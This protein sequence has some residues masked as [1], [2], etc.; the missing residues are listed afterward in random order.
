MSMAGART[1]PERADRL[2]FVLFA[3]VLCLAALPL[4]SNRLWAMG[5]LA[6][7]VL[8]LLVAALGVA[9]WRGRSAWR[10]LEPAWMPL[11][12]LLAYAGLL[13]GQ[14][15]AGA[16]VDPFHTRYYLIQTL[17]YSGGFAL[18]LL[19]A[20]SEARITRLAWVLVFA[21]VFQA[22]L[23]IVL[24][25][26]RAEY[27]LFF[28]EISHRA[29][30]SGSFVN[31][32][33]LAGYME[34]CLSL[35]IGLML[36][37]M[38]EGGARA[39]N[40]RHTA[41][42]V[43][44]FLMSEKIRLRLMLVVMVIALVLTRSRM[45]NAAFFTALLLVGA[46]GMF[47]FARLRKVAFWLVLSLVVVDVI[48]I[49]QWVGVDR[50]VERIQQTSVVREQGEREESL[51][52]RVE[53]AADALDLIRERPVFGFGGGTFYTAFPRVQKERADLFYDH[54][55]NDYAQIAA[56]T[57]LVG[58][59]LL[60]LVVLATAW[61]A[62][63]MLRPHQSRLA[64]GMGFG[65]L[66]AIVCIAMHST[67]DFNLQIPVNALTF[68]VILAMAWAVRLR[69]REEGAERG[70]VVAQGAG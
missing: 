16:T 48:V 58:L 43:M 37:K 63:M 15:L 8:A 39:R 19:L 36:A 5:L 51:S 17:T 66:M 46:V 32:N 18:V 26:L 67:V 22:M 65:V 44:R 9:V 61:R 12:A 29:Q 31:R 1:A 62:L 2:L 25:S 38:G 68:S 35:G 47:A 33:H 40:W 13:A 49:G 50:V 11:A 55:H 41:L 23:A 20:R 3:A 34:L 4:G 30:A 56:D 57:G 69:R 64:R 14:L 21:G 45:G 42:S 27:L 52:E 24:H 70:D 28:T 60:A 59:G 7:S 10:Q 6:T 54:A 53:P